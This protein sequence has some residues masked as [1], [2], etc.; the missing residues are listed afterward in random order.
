MGVI[1]G[2]GKV[3]RFFQW[4]WNM[5]DR[6]DFTEV[7]AT[8]KPL[9]ADMG[10]VYETFGLEAGEM[11]TLEDYM[12]DYFSRILKKLKEVELAQEKMKKR[13]KKNT[14]KVYPRF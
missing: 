10:P 7:I 2:A 5:A 13:K 4:T 14:D 9:N 8:G 3:L 1:R 6:L 11:S 12:Q